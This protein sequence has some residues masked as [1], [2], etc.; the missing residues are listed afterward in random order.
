MRMVIDLQYATNEE[1]LGR[2]NASLFKEA[3]FALKPVKVD[4]D[5]LRNSQ[6]FTM[7]ATWKFPIQHS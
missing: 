2:L 4:L 6:Y 1:R 5:V 3:D 7:D